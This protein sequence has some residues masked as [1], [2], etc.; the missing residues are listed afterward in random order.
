[1]CP[2][3]YLIKFIY[4]VEKWSIVTREDIAYY[5]APLIYWN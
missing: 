2:A 1:M 4:G 3:E 5:F